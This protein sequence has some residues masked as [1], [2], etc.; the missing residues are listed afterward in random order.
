MMALKNWDEQVK[1]NFQGD[2]DSEEVPVPFPGLPDNEEAG[3][4]DGFLMLTGREVKDIFEPLIGDVINLCQG[5]VEGIRTRGDKVAGIILVGGFGGSNYLYQY[6][7][8]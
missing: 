2:D 4:E 6:V 5:Q 8:Q 1:R 7:Q 3:V